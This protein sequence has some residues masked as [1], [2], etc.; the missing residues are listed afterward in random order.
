[1]TDTYPRQDDPRRG[2]LLLMCAYFCYCASD[3]GGKLLNRSVPPIEISWLR[4]L[5]NVV[6]MI[7]WIIRRPA[8]LK[9]ASLCLQI[10]RGLGMVASA[11]F[12]IWATRTLG[13]ADTTAIFFIAPVLVAILSIIFLGEDVGVRRWGAIAAG[14]IG[15]AVI[16][17]PSPG[18]FQPTALLP[19]LGA[20]GSAVAV[21][22]TRKMTRR[23]SVMTTMVWT[24]IT[25]FTV[26]S[27]A[28]SF[29][30]RSLTLPELSLGIFVG[31]ASTAALWFLTRAYTYADASFLAPFAYT[32]MLWS[33]VFGL[34]IFRSVPSLQT[35]LGAAFIVGSGLFIAHSERLTARAVV[36]KPAATALDRPAE[37]T[38][39]SN[40]GAPLDKSPKSV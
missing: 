16:F 7:P 17:R 35:C 4:F 15:M 19:L 36:Q 29:D 22:I 31:L 25:G 40:T 27:C 3:V 6:L 32:Q 10:L 37:Q 8:L 21:I 34:V 28:V 23:D 30:F 26:L 1:L 39:E 18:G 20:L 11:V 2:A 14:T 5:V 13:L 24:A 38:S 12:F 33:I 9:T